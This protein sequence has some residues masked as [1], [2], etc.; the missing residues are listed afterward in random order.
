VNCERTTERREGCPD[1][2]IFNASET[3]LFFRLT[4]E[5]TPKFKGKNFVGGK[6][7]K[8]HVTVLSVPCGRDREKEVRD[9]KVKKLRCLKMC[10][11]H[12]SSVQWKRKFYSKLI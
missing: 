2:D 9:W 11:K 12:A 8:D 4:P 7:A 6:L 10:E 3:G 5:R 1:R